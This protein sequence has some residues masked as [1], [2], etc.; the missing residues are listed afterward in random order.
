MNMKTM[1]NGPVRPILSRRDLMKLGTGA[2]VMALTGTAGGEQKAGE[3][4]RP[5]GVEVQTESG[6]KNTAN[7][8]A[9]NG[10]MDGTTEQI[11]RYVSQFSKA[12]LGSTA[13]HALNR[14]MVDSMACLISGFESEPARISARLARA[15]QHEL[16]STVLGY[17]V[18]TSPEMATF[19]NGSMLRH[20]DFNDLGP[21]GHNSDIIS[22]ILAI[23]EALHSSGTEVLVSIALG[24]ELMGALAD[25][26]AANGGYG[27]SWDGPFN[28]MATALAVGKL[29]RLDEDRLAN[30]LSLA[31][32]P[33]MP[34]LC[35]RIG[36]LSH[37]K[38][39][40]SSEASRTAVWA[41]LL[42]REGMTGPGKPFE[43]RHGLFDHVGRFREVRLP[44]NARGPMV[45]EM[46]GFKRTPTD[47]TSQ[48]VLEVIPLIRAWTQTENIAAI[49]YEMPFA[50]WQALADPP[51]WDPQNRETADHSL[52]Y[53]VS[54]A[55][56]DGEVY[57][58]SFTS[59]KIHDPAVRALMEKIIVRPNLN[60]SGNAPARITIRTKA[61]AEKS[62]DSIGGVRNAPPGAIDTPMTDEEIYAKF[63]RICKYR[64]VSENQRDLARATWSNLWSV[65]DV[66]VAM[67]GLARFGNPR[68]L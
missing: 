24:Y 31:L 43:N 45:V 47:G 22:G 40:H 1:N 14:T 64:E 44:M 20:A 38:G 56:L 13:V 37:W 2:M 16:K 18:T 60:W 59:E 30:A 63:D 65:P 51:K 4:N 10:P 11:V 52:P 49:L 33:H 28:G 55:L 26:N 7:R 50:G 62:W 48:G 6:W 42:A 15:T 21:G 54:R 68:S 36:S 9:G 53:L 46:M 19:A 29:M 34:M 58:D 5:V 32:V 8:L 66:A 67:Q 35:S 25:A 27:G 41:A 23:G 3:T 57:L 12:N 61:G 17:G 39:C